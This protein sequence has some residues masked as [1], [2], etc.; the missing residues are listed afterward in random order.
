MAPYTSLL[1]AMSRRHK[2]IVLTFL[3][4]SLQESEDCELSDQLR[5]YSCWGMSKSRA[6]RFIKSKS[7]MFLY[8][9]R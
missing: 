2:Q 4:E 6:T 5:R 7:F 9:L 3:K 8:E 1:R